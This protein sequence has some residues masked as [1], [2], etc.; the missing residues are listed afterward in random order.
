MSRFMPVNF[1]WREVQIVDDN[2]VIHRRKVM[3]PN[4]RYD[5]V[6]K[7]QF[8]DGEEYTL[9]IAEARSRKSHNAYFAQ[10]NDAFENLPETLAA[11][12]PTS[13][14]LRKW[15]LIETGWFEEKEFEFEGVNAGRDARRLG[16]FIRTEDDFA[17]IFPVQT[18]AR[19]WKV[20]IRKAKSQAKLAMRS[21]QEFEASKSDVLGWLEHAI[22]VERGTLKREAGQHA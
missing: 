7:R 8:S 18:G 19:Q 17:R 16:T 6:V 3:E 2:G 13:E 11:R 20:I 21:K 22:G 12:W 5:N 15:I 9:V 14:H 4:P 10:I 1:V